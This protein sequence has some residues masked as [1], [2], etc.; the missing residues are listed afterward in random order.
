MV[1][2]AG[3]PPGT[4]NAAGAEVITKMY[5]GDQ[6]QVVAQ[7]ASGDSVIVRAQRASADPAL[8]TIHPGDQITI[9]WDESAP[10]L[11]G[12][13]DPVPAGGPEEES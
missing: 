13:A 10:L 4:A 3:P 9:S 8:D 7:L 6:I 11:L 12:E 2:V 1:A 5:L